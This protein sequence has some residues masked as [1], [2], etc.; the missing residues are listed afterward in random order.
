MK[1]LVPPRPRQSFILAILWS[2][3]NL[4]KTKIKAHLFPTEI[5][6]GPSPQ[7]EWA[8]LF[9]ACFLFHSSHP[10]YLIHCSV[11]SACFG[12]C[13]FSHSSSKAGVLFSQ[14]FESP[15]LSFPFFFS[16]ITSLERSLPPAML[17]SLSISL[18]HFV[19]LHNTYQFLTLHH[20]PVYLFI[21]GL[22]R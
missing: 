18:S 2:H 8:R 19:F 1:S 17:P 12:L 4:F 5:L 7:L 10:A 20:K 21:L 13:E 6:G 15:T 3:G 9:W 22:L 11:Y 16:H 14:V